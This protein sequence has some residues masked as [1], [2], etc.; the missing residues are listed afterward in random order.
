MH[1]PGRKRARSEAAPSHF[2]DWCQGQLAA[3][4]LS[5]PKVCAAARAVARDHATA[6]KDLGRWAHIGSTEGNARNVHRDMLRCLEKA[7][8]MPPVYQTKVMLWDEHANRARDDILNVLLFYEVLDHYIGDG[9]IEEWTSLSDAL[10]WQRGVKSGVSTPVCALAMTLRAL[11]S[12]VM[13]GG[14]T[15]AMAST[16]SFGTR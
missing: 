3:G 13:L 7:T 1:G 15:Q 10:R 6:S 8:T 5:A 4:T 9:T 2:K 16:C 11:V 12:G 14:T